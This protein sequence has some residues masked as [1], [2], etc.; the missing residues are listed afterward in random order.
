MN[1]SLD[2]GTIEQIKLIDSK[3][4]GFLCKCWQFVIRGLTFILG[5][6]GGLVIIGIWLLLAL[7]PLLF[8][9]NLVVRFLDTY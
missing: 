6:F 2:M 3:V 1:K 7:V 8:V 5:G 4:Y 9:L